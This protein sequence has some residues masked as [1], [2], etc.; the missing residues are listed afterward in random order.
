MKKI[1]IY[2]LLSNLI[3][4]DSTID[5]FKAIK[6]GK[7]ITIKNVLNTKVNVN[8]NDSDGNKPLDLLLDTQLDKKD[9]NEIITL[10]IEKGANINATK[11]FKKEILFEIVSEIDSILKAFGEE[12]LSEEIIQ[13]MKLLEVLVKNN[14]DLNVSKNF[15]FGNGDIRKE[16]LL[17]YA[18]W[19]AQNN[20]ILEF[21]VKN[22]VNFS[23][24]KDEL[25]ATFSYDGKIEI[26][27]LLIKGGA[28]VNAVTKEPATNQER[29]SLINAIYGGKKEIVEYL[30]KAGANANVVNFDGIPAIN[31]AFEQLYSKDSKEM[32]EII[33]IL[34]KSGAIAREKSLL[35][36]AIRTEDIEFI[37]SLIEDGAD[38]NEISE[39]GDTPLLEAI[40]TGNI[41]IVE[42]LIKNNVDINTNDGNIVPILYAALKGNKDIFELL[43]KNGTDIYKID[44]EGNN[45]LLNAAMSGSKELIDYLLK[46]G[47]NINFKNNSKDNALTLL[48]H[49]SFFEEEFLIQ[50]SIKDINK[51]KNYENIAEILIN[52]GI[53][54]NSVNLNKKSALSYSVAIN[55]KKIVELLIAKGA[56]IN[57]IDTSGETI[58]FKAIES[59]SKEMT[60]F[61]IEKGLDVNAVNNNGETPLLKAVYINNEEIIKL[62][63]RKGIFINIEDNAGKTPLIIAIKNINLKLVNLLIS[64]GANVNYKSLNGVTPLIASY[65][66]VE[67]SNEVSEDTDKSKE[68]TNILVKNGAKKSIL[69]DWK[70]EHAEESNYISKISQVKINNEMVGELELIFLDDEGGLMT[71]LI[72]KTPNIIKEGDVISFEIGEDY[73]SPIK[74]QLIDG[75]DEIKK[76]YELNLDLNTKYDEY[77]VTVMELLNKGYGLRITISNK[78]ELK[79]VEYSSNSNYKK[80]YKKF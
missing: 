68:I 45:V 23:K 30:I 39:Y 55:S 37:E 22:G 6:S 58:L 60:Q 5:L 69:S 65:E 79:T 24:I 31:L 71:F 19:N 8:G 10:L 3:F 15:D 32:V 78:N 17:E 1:L 49:R 9:R 64:N 50:E 14:I 41:K 73:S 11:K 44:N 13:E 51:I 74:Y 16:S 43:E 77:M 80:Y 21:L 70:F 18:Y 56:N 26:L 42:L 72:E 4:C 7:I 46:I 35:A 12:I 76:Q 52:G 38:V 63:I 59:N 33:K 62:L 2:L 66:N 75:S 29:I 61:F 20:D 53:E 67:Y 27:E 54:V 28:D 34:K 47:L 48:M 25:L 57:T 40:N 36:K